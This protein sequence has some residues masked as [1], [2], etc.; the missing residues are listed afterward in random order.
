E[1]FNDVEQ[2]KFLLGGCDITGFDPTWGCPEFECGW[3]YT[4]PEVL[5]EY[6]KSRRERSW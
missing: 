4:P 3:R 1:L 5:A 2:G 6:E